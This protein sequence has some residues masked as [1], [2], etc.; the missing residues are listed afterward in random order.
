MNNRHQAHDNHAP[1]AVGAVSADVPMRCE[2][3]P[4]PCRRSS[5]RHNR[6]SGEYHRK[7]ITALD[8]ALSLIPGPPG[9]RPCRA[10]G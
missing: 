10:I 4:S 8:Q 9:Q 2:K 1:D 3:P 6:L 7:V 5:W